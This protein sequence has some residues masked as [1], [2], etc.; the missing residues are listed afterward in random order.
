MA[1]VLVEVT[2]ADYENGKETPVMAVDADWVNRGDTACFVIIYPD[3]TAG[4]P[5][6]FYGIPW[7]TGETVPVLAGEQLR[8]RAE[9]STRAT[10]LEGH[11]KAGA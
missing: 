3:D 8:V 7:Q 2:P 6:G 1:R 10:K 5:D 9:T 4:W 11:E